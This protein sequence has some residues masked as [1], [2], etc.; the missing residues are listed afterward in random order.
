MERRSDEPAFPNKYNKG[1]T[2]RDYLAAHADIAGLEFPS[3]ASAAR[4]LGIDVVDE[5]DTREMV[6]FAA[7]VSAKLSY[8]YADAMLAAR[9]AQ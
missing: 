6:Y 1:M 8:I 9:G 5:T 4:T 3:V 2:L 7:K